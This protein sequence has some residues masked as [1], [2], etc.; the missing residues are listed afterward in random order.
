[1]Q[2]THRVALLSVLCVFKCLCVSTV[3]LC[4]ST[5]SVIIIYR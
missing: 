4:V 1:M 2:W 5:F 3:C